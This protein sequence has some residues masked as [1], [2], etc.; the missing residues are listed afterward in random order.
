MHTVSNRK[1]PTR[2]ALCPDSVI[3][4]LDLESRIPYLEKAKAA[5]E[6]SHWQVDQTMNRSSDRFYPQKPPLHQFHSDL[7]TVA[8]QRV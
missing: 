3:Y 6:S 7:P 5:R 4:I 2:G 1:L 8:A